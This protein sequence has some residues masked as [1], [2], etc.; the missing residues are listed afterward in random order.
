M[1]IRRLLLAAPLL[2]VMLTGCAARNSWAM[3]S[4]VSPTDGLG[5]QL[6]LRNT[7]TNQFARFRVE[8]DGAFT[9]W[10]GK[11]VLFDAITWEGAVDSTRGAVLDRIVRA[12]GLLQMQ[13][14]GTDGVQPTWDV[15]L[16]DDGRQRSFI[17]HGEN[18]A[19]EELF[20]YLQNLASAR[21]ETILDALPKPSV[22]RLTVPVT[23]SDDT[24]DRP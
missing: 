11:D 13:S 19:L 21:F 6:E 7:D 4:G 23:S 12:R 24:A 8:P 2:L 9:Y 10:G 5:I 16:F 20:S 17:V 22:D 14:G 1:C 3:P 18:A 15:Q